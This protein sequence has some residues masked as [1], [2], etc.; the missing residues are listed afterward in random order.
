M[1][2]EII[3]IAVAVLGI[4]CFISYAKLGKL[5]TDK[6]VRVQITTNAEEV[7]LITTKL[8]TNHVRGICKE[9]RQQAAKDISDETIEQTYQALIA[10]I[11]WITENNASKHVSVVDFKTPHTFRLAAKAVF[12]SKAKT[13]MKPKPRNQQRGSSWAP[14]Q[15]H[16]T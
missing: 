1:I 4:G 7:E 2:F 13:R 6:S 3:M 9:E 8:L 15:C 10:N 14:E 5:Y 12:S 16:I 11:A